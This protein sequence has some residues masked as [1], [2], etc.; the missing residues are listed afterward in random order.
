[1][2]FLCVLGVNAAPSGTGTQEDPYVIA[3]GD[4]YVV[5]APVYASFT[6]PGDGNLNVVIQFNDRSRVYCSWR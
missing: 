1:M 2:A 4:N 3:D 5:N 6:A